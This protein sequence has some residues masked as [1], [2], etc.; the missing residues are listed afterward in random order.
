M[1][2]RLIDSN[3]RDIHNHRERSHPFEEFQNLFHDHSNRIADVSAIQNHFYHESKYIQ[4]KREVK[5]I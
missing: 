1:V 5:S 4:S 2:S 3:N